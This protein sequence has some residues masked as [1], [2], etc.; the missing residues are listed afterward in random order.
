M[1]QGLRVLVTDMGLVPSTKIG[2]ISITCKSSS[3][4]PETSSSEFFNAKKSAK[5]RAIITTHAYTCQQNT[6][7]HIYTCTNMCTHIYTHAQTCVH[8]HTTT[9][10]NYW[11]KKI[12]SSYYIWYYYIDLSILNVMSSIDPPQSSINIRREKN[13]RIERIVTVEHKI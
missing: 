7:T 5:Q 8:T 3:R 10:T 13:N 1:A 4:K 12:Y 6:Y 2:Q 11:R 9:H